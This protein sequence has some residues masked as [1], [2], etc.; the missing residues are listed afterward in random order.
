MRSSFPF[1][2]VSRRCSFDSSWLLGDV[3]FRRFLRINVVLFLSSGLVLKNHLPNVAIS[4]TTRSAS[5]SYGTRCRQ[6]SSIIQDAP[7]RPLPITRTRKNA[8]T[9]T[10]TSA[11]LQYVLVAFKRLPLS[12]TTYCPDNNKMN[13]FG[14]LSRR[15]DIKILIN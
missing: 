3:L 2:K 6:W 4:Y 7:S 5:T 9:S 13:R 11:P 15:R 12:Y 10:C 14:Y 8:S 1:S